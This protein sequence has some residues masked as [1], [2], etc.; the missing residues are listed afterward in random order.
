MS[1]DDATQSVRCLIKGEAP[2]QVTGTLTEFHFNHHGD[3]D[4][5]RL[6]DNTEVKFPPHLMAQL[7]S[8]AGV[9]D[10][11]LVQGRRHLTPTGD[12]CFSP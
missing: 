6:D 12:V 11:V 7:E 10:A 8:C 2:L 5:F 4:G 9:G 1:C 3:V